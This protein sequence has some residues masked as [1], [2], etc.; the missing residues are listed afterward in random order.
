MIERI[1]QAT[2][3]V[4]M[5]MYLFESGQLAD[6][7]IKA[8]SDA[9]DRGVDVYLLLDGYGCFNLK[10]RDRQHLTSRGVHVLEYNPLHYL[11]WQRN[12][13]RNHRKLLL[14][15]GQVAF[16]GGTGITDRF[17]PQSYPDR[18]WHEIMI[19]VEGPSVAHWQALFL[20]TWN[21]WS[22]APITLPSVR[23]LS[24]G[25]EGT[26]GRVA[27]HTSTLGKSE[28]L[29]SFITHIRHA[30]QRAWLAT[31]YFVPPGKLR[32]ALGQSAR[33]GT[34]VRLML[35]GPVTDHPAVRWMGRRHYERMLRNGVRI[36]EYQP[37]FLHAKVLLCD[38]RVSIGSTNAD[39]WNYHW[40][41][42]ANQEVDDPVI[43][44]QVQ[45]LF[46]HDFA[47][48]QEIIYPAWRLRPWYYRLRERLWGGVIGLVSRFGKESR[49]P[50]K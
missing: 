31:A 40:N 20:E 5:E 22:E 16:T 47:L 8:L 33:R 46:E 21:R 11:R 10:P 48:C 27:A 19:A 26:L 49:R 2:H 35:P 28:I 42:E 39:R 3:Y 13:F 6:R 45:A 12:L 36:F 24:E 34:D 18:Y 44:E 29:R 50:P 9:A 38:A 14:V 30:R 1:Q 43:A 17:D 25:A 32:R 7:F 41:L 4:L 15:D 23:F 37:R